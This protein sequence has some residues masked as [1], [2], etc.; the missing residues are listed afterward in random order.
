MIAFFRRIPAVAFYSAAVALAAALA[1]AALHFVSP[2]WLPSYARWLAGLSDVDRDFFFMSFE[3][4]AHF[5]VGLG[6]AGAV[7]AILYQAARGSGAASAS[8]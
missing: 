5:F 6:L 1:D 8:K 4:V 3:L 2:A 7:S